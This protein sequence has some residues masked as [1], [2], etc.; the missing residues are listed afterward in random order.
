MNI[1][2]VLK[3]IGLYVICVFPVFVYAMFFE[4]ISK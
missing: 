2:E 4:I 1:R 3:N